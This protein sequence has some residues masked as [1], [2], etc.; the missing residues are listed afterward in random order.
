MCDGN[1]RISSPQYVNLMVNK[2]KDDIEMLWIWLIDTMITVYL[3]GVVS[4]SSINK[5]WLAEGPQVHRHDFYSFDRR[6]PQLICAECDYNVIK[7]WNIEPCNFE[8]QIN[9]SS[10]FIIANIEEFV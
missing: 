9:P 10:V 8:C 3:G 2:N 1:I 4:S 7:F 5:Y 6:L